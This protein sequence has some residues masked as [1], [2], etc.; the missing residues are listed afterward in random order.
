MAEVLD[1]NQLLCELG[2][3]LSLSRPQVLFCEMEGKDRMEGKCQISKN[4]LAP[5]SK[6]EVTNLDAC[7]PRQVT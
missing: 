7:G 3:L 6:A 5:R 2:K 1:C 4:P